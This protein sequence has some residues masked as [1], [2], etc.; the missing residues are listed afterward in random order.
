[1]ISFR[2]NG[3]FRDQNPADRMSEGISAAV[4]MYWGELKG[5]GLQSNEGNHHIDASWSNLRGPAYHRYQHGPLISISHCSLDACCCRPA[6]IM[7]EPFVIV[8]QGEWIHHSGQKQL[9]CS[10]GHEGGIMDSVGGLYKLECIINALVNSQ[11][12]SVSEVKETNGK[13]TFSLDL[14]KKRKVHL[15]LCNVKWN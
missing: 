3:R 13:L 12:L 6:G 11:L 9:N 1:M 15:F 2:G 10:T 5:G 8:T 14:K 4:M 7:T